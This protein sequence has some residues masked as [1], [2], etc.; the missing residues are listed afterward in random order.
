MTGKTISL[1][2]LQLHG[3]RTWREEVCIECEHMG[4]TK[5]KI[6]EFGLYQ[7]QRVWSVPLTDGSNKWYQHTKKLKGTVQEFLT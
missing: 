3:E 2:V 6:K 7:K 4:N 5:K 1:C